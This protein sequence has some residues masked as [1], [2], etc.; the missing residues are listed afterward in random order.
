MNSR[1]GYYSVIQFSPDPS[2]LEAVNVGVVVYSPS[3]GKLVVKMSQSNQRI[4]KFFGNQ[5]WR[6]LNQAKAAIANRLRSEYFPSLESLEDFI[7]KRANAIRLTAPRL[8][9]VSS[10]EQ[11]V[12]ALYQQLLGE[13]MVGRK[14]RIRGDLKRK[15]SSAGVVDLVKK[16]VRVEIPNFRKAIEVPYAYQNGR[17]NLIAPVQFE[18]DTDSILTKTGKNAIEGRLL[19]ENPHPEFG[20]L[21]L[22]VVANFDQSVEERA[23][24]FVKRTLDESKVTFY[25]LE[26][27]EPLVEDIRRSAAEHRA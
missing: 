3:E 12:E 15:L 2:R 23:R 9:L 16:S 18:S 5:D 22:V 19:Y 7:S 21:R 1:K 27:L 10:V 6:F 8:M 20:D 13:E 11:D 25:Q 17:F 4:R 14:H 26:D 24:E